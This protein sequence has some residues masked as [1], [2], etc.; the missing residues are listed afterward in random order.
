MSVD[1]EFEEFWRF[2]PRK[3]A[4][5]PARKAFL[6]ALKNTSYE[7]II[8]ALYAQLDTNLKKEQGFIPHATT[9]LNQERWCD[10]IEMPR[11]LNKG[12][13]GAAVRAFSD[14]SISF[15]NVTRSPYGFNSDAQRIQS[16]SSN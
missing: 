15:Q 1:L 3:I 6:N 8:R 2:Y 13:V 9:W 10:D 11:N 14:G 7:V 12:V 16:K 5:S 4:K